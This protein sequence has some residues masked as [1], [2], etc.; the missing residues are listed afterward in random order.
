MNVVD[1]KEI[2]GYYRLVCGQCIYKVLQ[3]HKNDTIHQQQFTYLTTYNY[4]AYIRVV[5]CLLQ[6]VCV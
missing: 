1:F 4:N 3:T 5:F 2:Y 6:S